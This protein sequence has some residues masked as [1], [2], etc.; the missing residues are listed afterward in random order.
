[1]KKTLLFILSIFVFNYTFAQAPANDNCTTPQVIVIPASGTI[2]LNSTNVNATSDLFT[3]T[4]D[5][6]VP[7]DEVWFAFVATGTLNTVTITPNG[8]TPAQQVVVS[9]QNTNC[10]SGSYNICNASASAGGVATVTYSYTPGSQI[11]FSVETN[12]ADGTFQVC[13]TSTTLPPSPGSSCG[14]ASSICNLANFT[15]N[16]LPLNSTALMPSCFFVN[17]Q[18]PVFYQFT[19]GVT[20]TCAWSATPLGLAEYD[21]AMYNITAG[22]P[23]TEVACNYDY[24]SGLGYTIG[25]A[26]GSPTLC[27]TSSLLVVATDEMCPSITVTAGQTYLIVIDNFDANSVGFNFS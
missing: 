17:M 3:N 4:C 25:M 24:G 23:G 8:G 15:L 10:A 16:P 1:M 11:L 21:W 2:C 5:T 12:G 26:P 27:P 7:G 6:G 13:V 14:T 18:Q 9:M 19:V 22:C 20:G